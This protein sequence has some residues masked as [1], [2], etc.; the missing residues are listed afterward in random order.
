M[1]EFQGVSYAQVVIWATIPAILYYVACFAA[2]HFEAKRQG[3]LGVPRSE[4]PPLGRTLS[5]RGHLFIP[6]LS[7][8]FVMYSG[9]SAPLAALTG[10]LLCFP[11][12]WFGPVVLFILPALIVLPY[13]VAVDP[14]AHTVDLRPASA[15]RGGVVHGAD[16]ALAVGVRGKIILLKIEWR[17]DHRRDDR[18]RAQHAAG[19]AGLRLRR[20][21]H[22]H[23][24][25]DRPRHHLHAVGGGTVAGYAAAGA[26]ADHGGRH[27]SRHGHADNAGLHHHGVAAGAGAGEARRG[28]AGGAHVRLLLRDPVGH[29]AAGGA[30]GLCRGGSGQ[31]QPLEDGLG[32]SEDRRRRLRRALHVRLRAGAADDRRLADHHLALH[33]VVHRHRPAGGGLARLSAAADAATGSAASPSWRRCCWSR[34]SSGPTSSA[35]PWP[36][37][38][39]LSTSACA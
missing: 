32:G 33:R 5:A 17:P 10:T 30:G 19:G 37:P 31:I 7:I 34:R 12:A 26:G 9:Y 3:L 38:C 25:P 8:L 29:H 6:V 14:G 35:L 28:Q 4:L 21:H 36:R 1:A 11:V 13:R 24:H 15:G 23:R 18:R 39:W 2:V 27:R 22:R 16:R 20:H